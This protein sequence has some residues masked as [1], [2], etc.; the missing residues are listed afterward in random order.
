MSEERSDRNHLRD[1]ADVGGMIAKNQWLDERCSSRGESHVHI[2]YQLW[3]SSRANPCHFPTP[4]DSPATVH[5]CWSLYQEVHKAL[6]TCRWFHP[7][8][9]TPHHYNSSYS[10]SSSVLLSLLRVCKASVGLPN[11]FIAFRDPPA[12]ILLAERDLARPKQ[13]SAALIHRT[14][15][16]SSSYHFASLHSDGFIFDFWKIV[17]SR[18]DEC[19]L[20]CDFRF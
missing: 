9:R 18:R 10:Q 5:M 14:A 6:L 1:I 4:C 13:L 8:S 20:G 3:R 15:S 7:F 11:R 12:T 16:S 17:H 19:H 2:Q